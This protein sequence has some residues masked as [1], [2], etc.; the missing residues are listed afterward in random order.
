MVYNKFAY[1]YDY[2]MEDA[3]YE[4]WLG[5]LGRVGRENDVDV[6][7]VVDV[8][9]GT[10]ALALPMANMGYKVH[11]VDLSE[12]MLLVAQ[13]NANK[14]GVAIQF[15]QQDMRELE[16]FFP[17]DCIT[18]FCDSLNYLD[19]EAAVQET[20]ASAYRNLKVGGLFLFDV[21]SVYKMEQIFAK[22][23]FAFDDEEISYIWDCF[24]GEWDY[25]V[26]HELSFFVKK[27]GNIY[28]KFTESHRQR[29]F[30]VE[31]YVG[32]LNKAGFEILEISA[33]F[34]ERP[35]SKQSERIFFSCRK[36]S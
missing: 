12:D 1:I 6:K 18:I 5:F 8:G 36:K 11:G 26:E 2:L 19:S 4:K 22:H 15:F 21:H 34:T 17:I 16:G 14:L 35:P 29:T 3:P 32:W 24:Q 20:F 25:S 31:D 9:C 10:G 13:E 23:T 7:T 33:D 30:L 27:Q 28:E